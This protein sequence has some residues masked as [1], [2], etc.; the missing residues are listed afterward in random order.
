MAEPVLVEARDV[1]L[2]EITVEKRLRPVSA[3]AV[4]AIVASFA[5][6]GAQIGAVAL[7]ATEDGRLVLMCG[8]HRLEAARKMGRATIRADIW[9]CQDQIA[10]FFEVHENLASSELSNLELAQFLAEAKEAYE[11]LHP[12]TKAHISGGLARQGLASDTVSFADAMAQQ[13]G[14]DPR[15]IQRL[16]RLGRSLDPAAADVIRRR[17]KAATVRE[18]SFFAQYA[19]E[20][21]VEIAEAWDGQTAKTPLEALRVTMGESARPPAP[22]PADR[23]YEALLGAWNKAPMKARRSFLETLTEEMDAGDLLRDALRSA[24]GRR[25]SDSR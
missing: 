5:T 1:A 19:P 24:A 14:V 8:A 10:R 3:A 4:D 2:D 16:T 7:R 20:K 23:A 17:P 21:Q 11:S 18:L 13:R 12:A 6:I 22:S 25:A 15:S 9:R